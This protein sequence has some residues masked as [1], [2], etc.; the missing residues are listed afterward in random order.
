M[1]SFKLLV[2]K[3][4]EKKKIIFN[5]LW[6]LTD[7]VIRMVGGLVVGIWFARYV[8][9]YEF[10]LWNYAYSIVALATPIVNLGINNTLLTDL[11]NNETSVQK[12]ESLMIAGISLKLFTGVLCTSFIFIFSS[13]ES[14]PLTRLILIILS[15]Q[16]IFQ[17][18]DIFDL[19][20]QSRSESK[21]SVRA[22]TSAYI[23]VNIC[24]VIAL[25][26]KTSLYVFAVLNVFEWV[27]SSII[28]IIFYFKLSNNPVPKWRL[29]VGILKSLVMRSWPFL[30][31]EMLII[32]Y[33]RLDQI[34]LKN[35][36]GN[37]ELGRYSAAV[38][39]SEVW[40]FIPIA[41]CVS[42]YPTLVKLKNQ[43][44]DEVKQGFQKLFNLLA[45]ISVAIAVLF[46]FCSNIVTGLLYGS[47]YEGVGL[48]LSIH[49][50]TGVAVFLGS[51]SGYWLVLHNMQKHSLVQTVSGAVINILL[52]LILIPYYA[53]VGAAIATL[54]SQIAATVLANAFFTKTR[55]VFWLQIKSLRN[56]LRP[57]LKNYI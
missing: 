55:P 12:K 23:L 49:I 16:C 15:F 28:L 19:Y 52:N 14:E 50:W 41:I 38:R 2:A 33:T 4:K 26:T 30:I 1:N 36:V 27:V 6:V 39:L 32:L 54:I 47:R 21:N 51:A 5:S 57:S 34:M 9:L 22:K 24:K 45:V 44:D 7:K 46:T 10:G 3:L 53:G 56:L 31:A 35:M 20:Y 43:G 42:L 48:I 13:L 8:G 18:S 17:A 37:E 11:A 25:V 40:Y 29:D